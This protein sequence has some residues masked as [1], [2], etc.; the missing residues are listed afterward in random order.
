MRIL[1]ETEELLQKLYQG[2][3]KELMLSIQWATN[4]IAEGY[5]TPHTTTHADL[6]LTLA[7]KLSI[8]PSLKQKTKLHQLP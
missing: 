8:D 6:L 3:D 2:Q 1:Q 7:H 5:Q 4:F